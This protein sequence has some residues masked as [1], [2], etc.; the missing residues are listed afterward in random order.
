MTYLDLPIMHCA[1]AMLCAKRLLKKIL[2]VSTLLLVKP[3][4]PVTNDQMQEA[5]K[6]SLE[7]N[8]GI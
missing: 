7:N 6:E 1:V 2:G 3:C 4:V 5:N 8:G